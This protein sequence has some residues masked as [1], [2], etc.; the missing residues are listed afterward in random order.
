VNRTV[1]VPAGTDTAW[2]SPGGPERSWR[3]TT[4]LEPT[5]ADHPGEYWTRRTR[6]VGW[7]QAT[8]ASSHPWAV[9][10]HEPLPVTDAPP[11]PVTPP[12]SE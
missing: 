8:R 1:V 9:T 7:S 4:V 11:N 2:K 10:A 12:A 5:D 3:T 6:V